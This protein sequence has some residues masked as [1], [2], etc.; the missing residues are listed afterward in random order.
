MQQLAVH[1]QGGVVTPAQV[2]MVIVPQGADVQAE[3]SVANLDVGLVQ[4]GQPVSIKL[5]AYPYTSFGTLQAQLQHLA[6]DAVVDEK[7]GARFPATLRITTPD[8]AA[9][10]HNPTTPIKLAPGLSLTAEI[11]TGKRRVIDFLI[12]PLKQEVEAAG[13]E[14]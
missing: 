1:T 11:H 9:A 12:S 2:L 6:T 10:G 14:Q 7:T 5:E 4:P 8:K 13:R 3:V